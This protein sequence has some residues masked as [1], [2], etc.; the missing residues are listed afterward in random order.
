MGHFTFKKLLAYLI[1][2]AVLVIGYR[3]Y[4]DLPVTRLS[5]MDPA[6]QKGPPGFF[7]LAVSKVF[8][9]RRELIGNDAYKVY[10]YVSDQDGLQSVSLTHDGKPIPF[11]IKANETQAELEFNGDSETG[12]HKYILSAT[13]RHGKKSTSTLIVNVKLVTPMGGVVF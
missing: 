8:D 5:F 1:V 11:D 2:I 13:D 10:A 7:S 9:S 12:L 4:A 3:Q 6:F